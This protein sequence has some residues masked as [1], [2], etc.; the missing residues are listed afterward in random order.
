MFQGSSGCQ[1]VNIWLRHVV[2]MWS[3]GQNDVAQ[4]MQKNC[5]H[6]NDEGQLSKNMACG[7]SFAFFDL[8]KGSPLGSLTFHPRVFCTRC[9]TH[10]GNHFTTTHGHLFA[11]SFVRKFI[12]RAMQPYIRSQSWAAE[13]GGS[14]STFVSVTSSLTD[15]TSVLTT[16]CVGD[17]S[18]VC[19]PPSPL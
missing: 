7:L 3:R 1:Y 10:V 12:T 2:T 11:T 17:R 5:H 8:R 9:N 6:R 19:C 4:S 18:P 14:L 16:G 15:P 13:V